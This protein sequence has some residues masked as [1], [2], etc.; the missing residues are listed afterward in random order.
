M[1][2]GSRAFEILEILVR[3]GG[4]LI[5]K[6]QLME[7]V[8][9]GAVVQENTLQF[10]ISAI[11]KALG[12]DRGLLKT[13]SGRGYRLLGRWHVHEV[14]GQGHEAG[15]AERRPKQPF[16]TNVPIAGSTLI[17]RNA[18]RQ[19]LLDVLSAYRVVTLT[20]PGGIWKE[21]AGP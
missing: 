7:Q 6:Y 9:P 12:T 16:R 18:S 19:R 8:W 10:H 4:D 15:I 1:P 13:V 17:G 20:G 2:I 11:R 3:S 5:G 14:T 21:R